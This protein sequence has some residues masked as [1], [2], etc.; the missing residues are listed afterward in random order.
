[1]LFYLYH[2]YLIS[3]GIEENQILQIPLDDDMFTNDRDPA[4]LSKYIRSKIVEHKMNLYF[5]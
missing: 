2:D 3:Q 4:E 5:H 1:M